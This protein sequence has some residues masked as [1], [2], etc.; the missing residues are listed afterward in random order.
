MTANPSC[1]DSPQKAKAEE[2]KGAW[3][4]MFSEMRFEKSIRARPLFFF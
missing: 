3:L 2:F 1:M 4:D